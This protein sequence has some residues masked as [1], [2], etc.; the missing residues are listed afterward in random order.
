MNKL[1]LPILMAVLASAAPAQQASRPPSPAPPPTSF[2]DSSNLPQ[3]RIGRDDLVGI[4]VYDSPELTRTVRVSADGAIRLPMLK[5]RIMAAGLNPAELETAVAAALAKEELLVNPI[6]SVTVVE[7]R[8]RPITVSGSVKAPTTFQATGVVTLLDA[9]SRAGGLAANAGPEILVSRPPAEQ[10]GH[11]INLVQRISVKGLLDNADPA[12]NIR[13][14]GGEDIRVPEAG[15]FFVLGN[16]KLPGA[17]TIQDGA[18]SSVMKA[19]AL[20]QGLQPYAAKIAYIYRTEGGVSGK[21]EI[22]V[23]LKKIM[24]RKT[25]DVPLMA[26]DILYVP[27]NT[28]RRNAM[29]ALEKSILIAAGLGAAAL[30]IWH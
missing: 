29:S 2:S 8:S 11:S 18:E 16:V 26:N 3:E 21:S 12:L 10:D 19:L 6:V 20:S 25:P 1:Y 5:A 28:G 17:F 9:I 22:P 27:D 4:Y 23:E 13:L 7:Y 24:D 30:Y 15:R 14:E